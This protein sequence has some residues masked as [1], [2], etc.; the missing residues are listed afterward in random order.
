M[1]IVQQQMCE[2]HMRV[3]HAAAC[4]NT[5]HHCLRSGPDLGLFQV[6]TG[7]RRHGEYWT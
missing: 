6:E 1:R 4:G 3:A 2:W 7:N 5:P